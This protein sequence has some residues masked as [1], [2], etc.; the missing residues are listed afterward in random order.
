VFPRLNGD[1]GA[2]CDRLRK[3]Y[4]LSVVPG[5]FFQ[6]PQRIRI[7]IGGTTET[8]RPALEQLLKALLEVQSNQSRT[9]AVH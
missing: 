1:V 7:G 5:E 9:R 3:K 4:E 2:F 8:V 6:D